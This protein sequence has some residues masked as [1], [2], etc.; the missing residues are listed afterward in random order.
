MEL[1]A[2]TTD[3]RAAVLRLTSE[4]F[5]Q[6]HRSED[7]NPNEEI[8]S[9]WNGVFDDGRL[10]A[11]AA[12][13]HLHV[14]WDGALAPLGGVAAV[15]C[16]ASQRGRGHVARLLRDTLR[17]MRENGEYL[18][19]L[20]PFAYAFYRRYGWEW[21]G[22]RRTHTVPTSEIAS[23]PEG[24]HVRTYDGPDALEI[25]QPVYDVYARR[26]RSMATRQDAQPK[27][28]EA[29]LAHRDS[30]TTY[31]H[32]YHDPRSGDAQG[33]MTFRYPQNNREHP[34]NV[35]E[36]CALTPEAYRGLLTV[37]HY[38]GTQLPR[39]QLDAP[40]DSPLPLH[41]MHNDLETRIKPMFMGR[42]VDAARALEA[43]TPPDTLV[44]EAVVRIAD[45]TCDWNDGIFKVAS[46]AGRV[47][48]RRSEEIAGVALDIQSF[49]QAYWGYPSLESLRQ[50]GRI[51]VADEAQYRFWERLLPP[52]ISYIQDFF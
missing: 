6:G 40:A 26:Y 14:T 5:G 42:V 49:T 22:E 15:A 47:T 12:T 3:D 34:G 19:G 43:L 44:G 16:T 35:M 37:L 9:Y 52:C 48:V 28:W 1:R 8:R 41:V 31:V 38:Y 18:S 36:I 33:Y 20:Y 27:F 10:V 39:V 50:A 32:V 45:P 17:Q 46:E 29:A 13:H 25:V 11:C 4:A 51:A 30:K 21:V 23:Y 24:R 7:R 2:L